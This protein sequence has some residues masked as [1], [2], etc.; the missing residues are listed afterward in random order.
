MFFLIQEGILPLNGGSL[1]NENFEGFIRRSNKK[2]IQFLFVAM[3]SAAEVK[4]HLCIA[5]DQGYIHRAKFDELYSRAD[6]TS[7]IISGLIK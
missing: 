4:S 7:V 3:S 1:F 5:L 2:F 6:K